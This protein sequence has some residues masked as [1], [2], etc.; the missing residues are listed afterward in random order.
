MCELCDNNSATSIA[1]L[2]LHSATFTTSQLN[3]LHM[4]AGRELW[5]AFVI[6]P[7][8]PLLF[9]SRRRR[10]NALFLKLA[11]DHNSQRVS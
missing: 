6:G 4:L 1:F 11:H 9:A 3:F 8:P 7:H 10:F 5:L 2:N